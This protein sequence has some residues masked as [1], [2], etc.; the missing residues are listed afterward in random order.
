MALQF[1]GLDTVAEVRVNGRAVGASDNMFLQYTFDVTDAVASAPG[2]SSTLE[3]AFTSAV[4]HAQ[5]RRDAYPYPVPHDPSPPQYGAAGSAT[6]RN[7]VRKEQCSFGWDWGPAFYTAGVWRSARV[8]AFPAASASVSLAAVR[9]F[10]DDNDEEE[11]EELEVD[12]GGGAAAPP[13]PS[14]PLPP[15]KSFLLEADVYVE[16]APGAEGKVQVTLLPRTPDTR[17]SLPPA[18][19]SNST[20]VTVGADGTATASLS[21]RVAAPA[22]WWPVGYGNASLYS[23]EASFGAGLPLARAVGFRSVDLV[24]DPPPGGE[25]GKLFYFR[26]NGVPLFMRGANFIPADA[27]HA[28]A[29]REVLSG[30]LRSAVDASM[31][32]I[33]NWGGGVYQTDDF[34]ELADEMGLLVW[35]EFMFACAMYPR[36]AAFLAGVD[37]EVRHQVRRLSSHPSVFLWS[38]SNENEAAIHWYNASNSNPL[39]YGADY[40]ALYMDTVAAAAAEEDPSRP[41]WIS[42]PSNGVL[43]EAPKVYEWG[44]AYDPTMGDTHFYN[45]ERLCT[46]VSTLP[47]TRFASEYGFQSLPSLDTLLTAVEPA[48]LAWNSSA[49]LHRQHHPNGTLQ[50]DAQIRQHFRA[51]VAL[52]GRPRFGS[53]V[54]LAQAMQATCVK[55]EAEYY[56]SLRAESNAYTMGSLYWQL[57]SVWPAPTWSSLEYGG[58][59][60]LLHHSARRFYSPKL[61]L[62]YERPPGTL[63][64][65]A[66]ND[67]AADA[68]KGTAV[69]TARRYADGAVVGAPLRVPVSVAPLSAAAVLRAPV[70]EVLNGTAREEAFVTVECDGLA[71]AN[72]WFP[73][74]LK[75]APLAP[76]NVTVSE[77]RATGTGAATVTLVASAVAPWVWVSSSLRGARFGDN[78]LLLLPGTPVTLAFEAAEAFTPASLRESLT[79]LTLRDTY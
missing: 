15:P 24:T 38:G 51:P 60:K 47:R 62:A 68:F 54:Y 72:W 16:G 29:T 33:R 37:A 35:Q 79:V 18:G 52:P 20:A 14:D 40:V 46:N 49:V 45:Y 32:V 12:V 19:L 50:L 44:N 70:E 55:A 66:V 28:R 11:E 61:V 41:F 53:Y 57:N 21:L 4:T 67:D 75:D 3:V 26:V 74:A 71:H 31:L 23:L 27:F 63:S 25:E 78:G 73:A 2:G 76:A 42:S 56:R 5:A 6:A 13:T 39:L 7:F 48:G 58:R 59:W 9:V 64:V 1:D 8:L 43:S 36:D 69:V 34:Y 17:G 22:L 77:V 65:Y 30:I 10:P